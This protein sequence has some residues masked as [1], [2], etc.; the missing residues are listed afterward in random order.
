MINFLIIF[1]IMMYVQN[2]EEFFD[3]IEDDVKV[4][5]LFKN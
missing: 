1:Y 5:T 2:L 3:Y 4:I